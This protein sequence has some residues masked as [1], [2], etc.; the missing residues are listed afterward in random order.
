MIHRSFQVEPTTWHK[1]IEKAAARGFPSTSSYV[2]FLISEDLAGRGVE[3]MEQRLVMVLA[4]LKDAI[5]SFGTT[6]QVTFAAVFEL[7]LLE[8]TALSH[9]Q[10]PVEE[11]MHTLRASIKENSSKTGWLMELL[12]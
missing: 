2:R 5:Q 4:G 11:I 9:R 7:L 1:V 10:I 6:Q 8:A 3:E 12:K